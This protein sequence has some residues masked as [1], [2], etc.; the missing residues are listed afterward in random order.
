VAVKKLGN[1]IKVN[2]V[3]MNEEACSRKIVGI[4]A[5]RNGHNLRF[6]FIPLYRATAVLLQ[7]WEV[8]DYLPVTGS[9]DVW[10]VER[11]PDRRESL[12]H[13]ALEY[14]VAREAIERWKPD[15]LFFD[16][17]LIL[18]PRLRPH[19]SDS[20]GYR[21]DFI[22][23]TLMTLNLLQACKEKS[24]PILGFVKRTKMSKLY[25]LL[26]LPPI[27]DATLLNGILRPREYVKP[28]PLR[29]KMTM[30]LERMAKQLGADHDAVNILTSYVK[31]SP[32]AVYRVEIPSFCLDRL[33]E[34]LSIAF[35]MVDADGIPYPIHEADRLSRISEVASDIHLLALFET[36]MDMVRRGV[37]SSEDLDVFAPQYGNRWNLGEA[38]WKK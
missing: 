12:L 38:A 29:N 10:T 20:R 28:F 9:V 15:Y 3:L 27:R 14:H 8:V 7:N 4:D 22:F 24:V 17:A 2:R 21:E 26:N 19:P 35:S 34:L 1:K 23:T 25:K 36:A 33:D 18:N 16:G 6:A 30:E 5:G 32:V 11:D 31:T 13:M 37:L